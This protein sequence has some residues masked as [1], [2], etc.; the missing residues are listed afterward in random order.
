MNQVILSLFLT[1]LSFFLLAPFSVY[2]ETEIDTLDPISK[3]QDIIIAIISVGV[4]SLIATFLV[5]YWN[6]K[7]ETNEKRRTVLEN[8]Y[9]EVKKPVS[10]M[11]N[12]I[13]RLLIYLSILDKTNELSNGKKLSE[14]L[15]WTYTYRDLEYYK[16][17]VLP[18]KTYEG[19]V[20]G[21]KIYYTKDDISNFFKE[22]QDENGKWIIDMN[23]LT[24]DQKAE[25]KKELKEFE[26][27]F[28]D[29]QIKSVEFSISLRQYYTEKT[30][31]LEY[32]AMFEYM[33]GSFFIIRKITD[34]LE[35]K[36]KI[37][38][39]VSSY[40]KNSNFLHD[41]MIDFESKLIVGDL[42]IK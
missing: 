42:K 18:F 4:G 6:N 29:I 39:L 15:A 17:K 16:D 26:N 32:H 30:L 2:A 38:D 19:A 11:D 8:Y 22:L 34:Y 12:F 23:N 7:K 27:E 24:S 40:N 9:N 36:K 25:I 13:D 10:L 41:M 3:Y 5:Q 31:M 28:H 14:Y 33:M 1:F 20:H 21:E 35:D 37:L